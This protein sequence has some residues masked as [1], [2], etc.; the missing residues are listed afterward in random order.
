M[1]SFSQRR[2]LPKLTIQVDAQPLS[3]LSSSQSTD[4]ASDAA[5]RNTNPT[6]KS[7]YLCSTYC[8][9]RKNILGKDK[10]SVDSLSILSLT[11]I[12]NLMGKYLMGKY[13][14][15]HFQILLQQI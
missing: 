7:G 8:S 4:R 3:P 13:L 6:S 15:C 14:Q 2:G 1:S 11:L 12:L 5:A 10:P 9:K